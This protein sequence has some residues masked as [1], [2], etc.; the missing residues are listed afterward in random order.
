MNT[1]TLFRDEVQKASEKV[2]R[3]HANDDE[4][5]L[6]LSLGLSLGSSPDAC[7]CHASKKDEADAGNGGGDG[8][9]ALALR[10]AP[11]AGEPMVHPKRQRATTNSSSSSSI[12]GEY[13]GGA[14]AAAVPA[15]HDDDDR[16][17][18]ITAAST[19]NRPG[20]VV[21]RTRCSAPTVKDGCQWRKYG[22]KTAKGNP[23]PRGYYRCTGAPGC[24]V[25]K[26]VQRCNH[27]TSV[28]VTT[29][30]GVHNHPIT[31]YAAALPPSSSSS[32][33]AAVAML[34]S[35]SS[36]STWSELQRAMPA[37]QSSWSQR[38]YP[39]QAD[40]VAKAIWDPKFQATVAAAVA[41]YVRDRE[42][43]ARVAGGKG[44]GE[45]FNLAPPC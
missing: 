28:L 9:L 5:G 38:N 31:P 32:S 43:S 34:A 39:I 12:C 45:L 29:Y 13:G 37:A 21:L 17:C 24:P 33:S 22:Q 6:F 42:Q 19:A 4:A 41:S 14:A 15:G 25:K 18:M 1:F 11:A 20:R 44:A 27:D 35:S 2:H 23:W 7:Q 40:V 26:Q 30:D 10:C 8:Y 3:H 36:S 16:S